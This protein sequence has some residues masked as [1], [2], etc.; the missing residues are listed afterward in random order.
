MVHRQFGNFKL[1]NSIWKIF[2]IVHVSK[3]IQIICE[4]NNDLRRMQC[5]LMLHGYN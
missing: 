1:E 2:D 3:Y 4:E 5:N